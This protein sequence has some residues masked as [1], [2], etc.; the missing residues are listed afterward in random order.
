MSWTEKPQAWAADGK[1][2]PKLRQRLPR[3][4]S[5]H[6]SLNWG[7]PLSLPR[8]G[9]DQHLHFT[10]HGTDS[11]SVKGFI[12]SFLKFS[13]HRIPLLVP[14]CTITLCPPETVH[15]YTSIYVY[16]FI[17]YLFFIMKIVSVYNRGN[18]NQEGLGVFYKINKSKDRF[19]ILTS[20]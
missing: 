13:S 2:G 15:R 6:K 20:P 14:K 7:L 17:F 9:T 1:Q 12:C 5:K 8:R 4:K 3:T 10:V 16:G 18:K 11:D 19:R